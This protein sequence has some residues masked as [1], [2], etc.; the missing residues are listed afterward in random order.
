MR[1]LIISRFARHIQL[2]GLISFREK[3]L[4]KTADL[5]TNSRRCFL[6]LGLNIGCLALAGCGDPEVG[7]APPAGKSRK[8]RLGD[9]PFNDPPDPKAAK[10]KK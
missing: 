7:S 4:M 3:T 6:L 1:A 10:K 9:G 2:R 8:E 5:I